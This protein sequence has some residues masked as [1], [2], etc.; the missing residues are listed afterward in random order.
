VFSK[1]EKEKERKEKEKKRKT[2]QKNRKKK[3]N[4]HETLDWTVMEV[5]WLAPLCVVWCLW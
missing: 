3:N 4:S 1:K 5:W 2:K